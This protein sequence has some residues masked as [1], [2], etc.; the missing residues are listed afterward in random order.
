MVGNFVAS[1]PVHRYG[2]VHTCD[3]H[4]A[5]GTGSNASPHS[6]V[7]A[8]VL[9]KLHL[10]EVEHWTA[11]LLVKIE[12]VL[13][14]RITHNFARNLDNLNLNEKKKKCMEICEL[15]IYTHIF[16]SEKFG[17]SCLAERSILLLPLFQVRTRWRS[18][19][20]AHYSSFAVC[21]E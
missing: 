1:G 4:N 16:I 2:C 17:I 21:L 10:P 7:F 6:A 5:S 20:E 18:S 9:R 3:A 19:V 8:K 11:I 12:R 13:L 14:S 15:E